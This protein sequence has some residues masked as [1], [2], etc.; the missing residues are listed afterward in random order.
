MRSCCTLVMLVLTLN[1]PVAWGA[2][3][4]GLVKT[5]VPAA[6]IIRDGKRIAAEQGMKLSA[7]DILKTENEGRLGVILQ[8]DS[9]LTV[10][11]ATELHLKDFQFAPAQ[12]KMGM[13]LRLVRGV[14][15]YVSG[16]I[17]KLAPDRI[18]FETPTATIGVRGTRF[19]A[20]VED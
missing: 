17:G 13:I 3:I 7:G 18:R 19:I 1:A 11:P 12:G 10:G 8:D 6:W 9:L 2:E 5:A 15:A 20:V 14:A 16:H 4:A